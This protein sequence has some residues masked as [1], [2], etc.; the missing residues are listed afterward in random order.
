M[1]NMRQTSLPIF[2]EEE[3]ESANIE[4]KTTLD[5]KLPKDIW[6]TI[7]AFANTDGGKIVFG[8][9]PDGE[10]INLS[11]QAIDSLQRDIVSLCSQGFSSTITPD[12]QYNGG[13]L[14]VFIPPSPAQLRPV[15]MKTKGAGSG[16]YVREG[17]SNRIAND[18]MVRRFSVAARGG[19]ETLHF[20]DISYISC[21]DMSLVDDYIGLVNRRKSNMYQ[22]F[23][24]EEI[25]LKLRAVNKDLHPT[26]FG[27][28]AFGKAAAPQEIIAPTVNV[29]ITQYPGITKVNEDNFQETY[30]DNR[31]FY[32]N[33]KAQFDDAFSFMKSKLP[34][35]GTI[36]SNGKRRDYLVI[37][38]VALRESLAN[39][40]A[41]RDYSTYSSPIQIDIFSDRIE[42]INPGIS[43]V[44][45][46]QLDEAPSA[47]RNPLLMNY[48][49]DYGITDQKARGIRTIKLSLKDAGLLAPSFENVGQSFKATLFASAFISSEDK[50]WLQQF[51]ALKLNERQLN[52]LAHVKNNP[53]G[54]SNSEYRDYNS[55]NNVRDDKKANKELRL[56][57]EKGVLVKTGENRARRYVLSNVYN[58]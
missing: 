10:R 54:I 48:L 36:D 21:F 3:A 56:L 31:E 46:A 7:S 50:V 44:P 16:T 42:F 32:G 43:L 9:T 53:E 8:V 24:A 1:V 35:R 25:L 29:V 41:H 55:M 52:A 27:L 23:T 51:T 38:E 11:A 28:L 57:V 12:V 30:I 58:N 26:L 17:S 4:F 20:D 2:I 34:V 33:V 45:I 18:E 15:Y 40:L 37:P 6:H 39:A 49:K 19:A 5:G 22:S 14:I 47:T 13:L